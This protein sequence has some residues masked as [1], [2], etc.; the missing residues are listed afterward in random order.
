M[1]LDCRKQG[2]IDKGINAIPIAPDMFGITEA[3][4]S[5]VQEIAGMAKT[6]IH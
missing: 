2:S 3:A 6:V 1:S 4:E 5:A